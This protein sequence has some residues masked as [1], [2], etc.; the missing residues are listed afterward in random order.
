MTW[1]TKMKSLRHSGT[2]SERPTRR[3][4][5][6]RKVVLAVDCLEE[7]RLLSS[8]QFVQGTAFVDVNHNGQL[9]AGDTYQAGATVK[10]YAQD[11]T[12]LLGTTTTDSNGSYLF[13]DSN[14]AG[15]LQAYATYQIV[16]VPPAGYTNSAAQALAELDTASIV[17]ANKIQVTLAA[18]AQTTTLTG[19]ASG[20]VDDVFIDGAPNVEWLGQ[21]QLTDGPGAN[22][23]PV[24]FLSNCADLFHDVGFTSFAT[25]TQP[26]STAL[27]GPNA[28][29]IAY[30]FNHYDNAVL[31]QAQAEGLQL[32]I[33]KL[34]NDTTTDFSSGR[35]TMPIAG[36][37]YIIYDPNVVP[38][39]T[40]FMTEAAGKHENAI[41][42]DALLGSLPI[43]QSMLATRSFN[44]AN[45]P[46]DP[47]TTP[48]TPL[49]PGSTAS[50]G[51]WTNKNG[52]ALILSLNGGQ[53]STALANWLAASFPNLFPSSLNLTNNKDV[54]NY[55]ASLKSTNNSPKLEAQVLA[56]ALSV[57]V[58]NSN[59]AG[60]TAAAY[61]FHVS[62]T[63]TGA[64]TY[65]V[66]S[67][68]SVLGLANGADYSVLVILQAADGKASNGT[69]F[70]TDPTS[71]STANVLFSSVILAGGL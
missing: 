51:F 62:T 60:T 71:R 22:G 47:P 43:G 35:I 7:R 34:E 42:L 54:A 23:A 44:F 14:V 19:F 32:A 25:V 6:P 16:E 49:D 39:A 24:N 11:G 70:A 27:L 5:R 21:L 18:A 31:P 58:T 64:K 63:G 50:I 28:G 66:G 15:G 26:S 61:G 9:G 29:Q 69:L 3:S 30:L 53:N 65:N 52:Q 56:T 1:Y 55:I 59:L 41:V 67:N 57:Y 37:P 2:S 4:R 33:W 36:N 45:T 40:A 48:T 68:G 46:G 17:G 13:D 10:L 12:T 8:G 38:A 20:S